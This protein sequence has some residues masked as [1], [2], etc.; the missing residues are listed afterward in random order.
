MIEAASQPISEAWSALFRL[1]PRAAE[2][3]E[4]EVGPEE[5]EE[6][7]ALPA[8]SKLAKMSTAFAMP[9]ALGPV[10]TFNFKTSL[11]QDANSSFSAS[12]NNNGNPGKSPNP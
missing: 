1:S 7:L 9:F 6:A 10:L 5:L 12:S 8:L 4:D 2:E 11:T 3:D